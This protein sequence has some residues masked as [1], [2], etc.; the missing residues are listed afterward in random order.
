MATGS[1]GTAEQTAFD[2]CVPDLRQCLDVGSIFPQL[3]KKGLLTQREKEVLINDRWTNTDK[4]D[5]LVVWLPNKPAFF[6]RFID[7]LA[8]SADGTK[9]GELVV[10]LQG[11]LRDA[12]LN[13]DEAME[14][15]TPPRESMV[16][17]LLLLL[18]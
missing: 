4:V 14:W 18:T 8:D 5:Q 17:H 7:C 10:I 2:R 6:Q 16:V 9:H 12:Q 3:C 13:N 15:E 1:S 11:A